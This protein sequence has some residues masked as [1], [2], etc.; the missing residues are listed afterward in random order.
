MSAAAD[1]ISDPRG[2]KRICL[3]CGGRFYDLNKRPVICPACGAEFT[4][5]AR[6]KTRRAR[7][8][9]A[10]EESAGQ[11]AEKT[12][13]D[14]GAAEDED[15]DEGEGEGEGA[16]IVSLDDLESDDVSADEAASP[17]GDLDLDDDGDDALDNLDVDDEL[18]EL[19]EL[20]PDAAI[21][22]AAAEDG[23]K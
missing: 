5:E 2:L 21:G 22:E 9:D 10:A 19:D 11:V 15:E 8:A 20:E 14:A 6:I 1:K 12:A 3:E 17:K 7:P 18:G 4:G 23:K 13:K 16:D